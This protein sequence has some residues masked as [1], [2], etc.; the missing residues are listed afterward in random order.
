M[1]LD[2]VELLMDLEEAFGIAIPD[3]EA[4]PCAPRAWCWTTWRRA[5]RAERGRARTWSSPFAA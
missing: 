4:A 3:E 1:G 5:C 2:S